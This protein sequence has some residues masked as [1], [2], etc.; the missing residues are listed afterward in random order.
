ME[1]AFIVSALRRR[2]WVVLVFFLLGL[3]PSVLIEPATGDEYRSTADLWIA[4]S[5]RITN[6][7]NNIDNERYV[8]GQL[9]VLGSESLSARVA[10]RI[11]SEFGENISIAQLNYVVEIEQI[12]ETDVVAITTTIDSPQKAQRI[13]QT[14]AEVYLEGLS[15]TAVDPSQILQLEGE[16][17]NLE[18]SLLDVN[19]RLQAAMEPWLPRRNRTT[20]DPIPPI[21]TIDPVAVSQRQLLTT[22]LAQQKAAL[23]ELQ[24]DSRLQVNSRVISAAG[25]PLTPVPPGANFLL[26]GGLLGGALLGML[27]ATIWAR[28]SAKVLDDTIVGELLGAPVVAEVAHYRSLARNP[29]AAFQALPRTAWP[30]VDQLCVR[31][32]ALARMGEPL[33]VLVAGTMR[34][35]G[36]TTLTLAMA[37]RFAA[38]GSSVVVVDADVRDPRISALFNASQ[39]GGISAII[40]NAGSVADAAGRSAF[41]R[42]M[43]P[44]VT[45]LGQGSRRGGAT[46]RRDTVPN[47]LAAAKRQ[48]DIVVV[49]GG[50]MLDLASTLQLSTAV[51]A[52]VLAVPMPRQTVDALSDM[53]RQLAGLGDRLLPVVTAPARRRAKGQIAR[54]SAGGSPNANGMGPQAIDLD[55]ATYGGAQAQAAAQSNPNIVP[56]TMSDS[57]PAGTL[58]RQAEAARSAQSSPASQAMPVQPTGVQSSGVQLGQSG[59]PQ[60]ASAY[61]VDPALSDLGGVSQFAP[62][63]VRDTEEQTSPT[64]ANQNGSQVSETVNRS[65]DS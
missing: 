27:V 26:V 2:F 24:L 6:N 60:P 36:A 9:E 53:G 30:V 16:I 56:G 11:S 23:S 59:S 14:F 62:P 38:G 46:L 33:T 64:A 13:S 42:T 55:N 50:P 25:L 22:E 4:P 20:A 32:E 49:D 37:E 17:A 19:E 5:T 1:L 3:L 40:T 18:Q 12:P 65:S 28:F 21:E 31:S 58:L 51:D 35:A 43:D 63:K 57:Y 61:P 52:V 45:V 15:T 29:M 41:T 34:S 10:E 48:A 39:D 47:V 44:A 7:F 8:A 54:P